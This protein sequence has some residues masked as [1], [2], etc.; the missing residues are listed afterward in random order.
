MAAGTAGRHEHEGVDEV[1]LAV[2]GEQI[3]GKLDRFS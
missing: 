2:G 1:V 3:S